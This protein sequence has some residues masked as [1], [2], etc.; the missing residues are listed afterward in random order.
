MLILLFALF[1]IIITGKVSKYCSADCQR[2]H[3]PFHKRGCKLLKNEREELEED[4]SSECM[5][6]FR[7]DILSRSP[8]DDLN[9]WDHAS[10]QEINELERVVLKVTD[11]ADLLVHLGY[12]ESDTIINGSVYYREA[13]KYFT[14]PMKYL[15]HLHYSTQ[16]FRYEDRILLLLC[17]LGG[18][19]G[20]IKAWND[21][22]R[23]RRSNYLP[24]TNPEALAI[25]LQ[26]N[27]YAEDDMPFQ[28]ILLLCQIKKLAGFRNDL[29]RLMMYKETMQNS[30]MALGQAF[31]FEDIVEHISPYLMGHDGQNELEAL[32]SSIRT[33]K[34]AFQF[35][36]YAE[37]LIHF[38][39]RIPI[40]YDDAPKLFADVL[41]PETFDYV[42]APEE[43]WRIFQDYIFE[44]PGASDILHEFVPEEVEIE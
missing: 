7:F 4:L 30:V 36:G 24:T 5:R 27:G 41:N 39:D 35:N 38:R 2:K 31:S 9:Y 18:D 22:T 10:E 28:A 29:E 6:R 20:V 40:N 11:Y 17:V 34:L 13:L 3:F 1:V 21:T 44:T 12:R 16:L 26:L 23:V 15:G 19:E 25:G 32:P 33:I 43:Y 42:P 37:S 14:L 8:H